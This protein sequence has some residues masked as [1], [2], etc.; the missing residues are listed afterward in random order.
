[1]PVKIQSLI[2]Q[3]FSNIMEILIP[4]NES[5]LEGFMCKVYVQRLCSLEKSAK[6]SLGNYKTWVLVITIYKTISNIS[7]V[8]MRFEK[9]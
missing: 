6:A 3:Q 5:Y 8:T 9:R 7:I 1:M 4:D 2:P